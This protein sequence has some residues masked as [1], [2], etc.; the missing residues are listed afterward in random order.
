MIQEGMV[1]RDETHRRPRYRALPHFAAEWVDP[2]RGTA[3]AWRLRDRISWRFPLTSRIVDPGARQSA[4]LFLRQAEFEGLLVPPH[5]LPADK[6]ATG[7]A[8]GVKGAA[9]AR[10]LGLRVVLYGSAARNDMG[11]SSDVDLLV[12]VGPRLRLEAMRDAMKNVA[13]GVNLAAPRKVDVRTVGPASDLPPAFV[14]GVRRDGFVLYSNYEGGEY[15][16]ILEG[17]A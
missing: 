9:D 1:E 12:L 3:H 17:P 8:K 6:W 11:P 4:L 13:A 15:E 16:P 14:E 7:R 5:L 2:V 10:S